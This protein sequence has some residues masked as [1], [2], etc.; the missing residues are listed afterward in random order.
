MADFDKDQATKRKNAILD[1]V[2]AVNKSIKADVV[3][4]YWESV[5]QTQE[6]ASKTNRDMYSYLQKA[7]SD[8]G[9][10]LSDMSN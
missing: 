7:Y 8:I 1:R 5:L 3:D 4:Y 9:R 2:A 6:E 10:I